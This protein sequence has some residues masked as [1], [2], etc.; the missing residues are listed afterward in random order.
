MSDEISEDELHQLIEA[1]R[2]S[3]DAPI[4]SAQESAQRAPISYDFRRPQQ[5]NEDQARR[6]EGIHEPFARLIAATLS[7]NMRMVIDVDLAFC[8][9]LVYSEF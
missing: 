7:S 4:A 5:V 6:M 3:R 9:Q 2:T 8:S 1:A